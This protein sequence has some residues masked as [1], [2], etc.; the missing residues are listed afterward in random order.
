MTANRPIEQIARQTG[1]ASAGALCH[2]FK[3]E[4]GIAPSEY[5]KDLEGE[6]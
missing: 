6:H 5:R 2:T 4:V 3:R 1:F